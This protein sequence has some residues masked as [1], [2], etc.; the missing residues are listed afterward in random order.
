M[1]VSGYWLAVAFGFL[2]VLLVSIEN[3]NTPSYRKKEKQI[4]KKYTP[5]FIT[6]DRLFV[7]A[8]LFY[9]LFVEA[10]YAGIVLSAGFG[11]A[12][13]DGGQTEQPEFG[14]PAHALFAASVVVGFQ[15]GFWIREVE[16]RIRRWLH[17]WAKVPRGAWST[18]TNIRSSDFAFD[19]YRDE[20]VLRAPELRTVDQADFERKTPHIQRKWA[21][22]CCVLYN[23]RA[24]RDAD[25]ST[26]GGFDAGCYDENFF[27]EYGDDYEEIELLHRNLAPSMERYRQIRA[28]TPEDNLQATEEAINKDLEAL[29]TKLYTFIACAVRSQQSKETGVATALNALGF[30]LD[31]EPMPVDWVGIIAVVFLAA[32]LSFAGAF[33]IGLYFDR[34]DAAVVDQLRY[35][36]QDPLKRILWPISTFLYLGSAIVAGR[37]YRRAQV[38]GNDWLHWR[39]REIERPYLKYILAGVLGALASYLFLVLMSILDRAIDG[40]MTTLVDAWSALVEVALLSLVWIFVSG[41]AAGRAVYYRDTPAPQLTPWRR[42]EFVGLDAVSMG[43][44][45][46]VSTELYIFLWQ[47]FNTIHG[48]PSAINLQYSVSIAVLV[49][50]MGALIGFFLPRRQLRQARQAAPWIGTWQ[51]PEEDGTTHTISLVPGGRASTDLYPEGEGEWSLDDD[52]SRV[53]I[54]WSSGWR[55]ILVRHGDYHRKVAYRSG[56]PQYADPTEIKS[57]ERIME[58]TAA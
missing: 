34:F 4:F 3:F 51:I 10:I 6:F 43:A 55:D 19:I 44:V 46:F 31:P 33:A 20:E 8:L 11:E 40:Q 32:V 36:P 57:I 48:D 5:R 22:I 27:A 13:L 29:A 26:V 45:A 21:R 47:R 38:R 30:R 50:L 14:S 39:G 41:I 28:D 53:R 12:I 15:N 37:V 52:Q 58:R 49:G 2:I 24:S 18:I 42:A 54:D 23:I 56:S 25:T 1:P 16:R 9:L 17:W 35:I 7:R